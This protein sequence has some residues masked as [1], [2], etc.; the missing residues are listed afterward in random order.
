MPSP[1]R[2]GG[3]SEAELSPLPRCLY[4]N[5]VIRCQ[6]EQL[7]LVLGLLSHASRGVLHVYP[8]EQV[9]YVARVAPRLGVSYFVGLC[10]RGAILRPCLVGEVVVIVPHAAL[11]NLKQLV[12]GEVVELK[13]V[14]EA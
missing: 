7:E 5:N 3:M 13:L 1:L 4:R 8:V 2:G 11:G 12:N 6:R 10:Q 9:G 14:G